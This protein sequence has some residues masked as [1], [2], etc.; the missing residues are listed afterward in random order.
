MVVLRRPSTFDEGVTQ[1][2]TA[3]DETP[4]KPEAQAPRAKLW[5]ACH[6]LLRT[7]FLDGMRALYDANAIV[8]FLFN[9]IVPHME[10]RLRYDTLQTEHDR[11]TAKPDAVAQN[12][13]RFRAI[14]REMAKSE[15]VSKAKL[16]VD[17][18][19]AAMRDAMCVLHTDATV[20]EGLCVL[21]VSTKTA[22]G[23]L[24]LIFKRLVEAYQNDTTIV[25][26]TEIPMEAM[27]LR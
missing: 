21:Y 11:A 6:Q 15:A 5:R 2:R 10:E 19:F 23:A 18:D 16:G 12:T 7:D 27:L 20:A 25:Q 9:T 22:R 1:L 14:L 8:S 17:A 24:D 3:V 26:T 13:S 4:A